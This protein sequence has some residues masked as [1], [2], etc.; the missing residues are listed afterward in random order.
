VDE[1][2]DWRPQRLPLLG[3]VRAGD[4]HEAIEQSGEWIDLPA[5]LRGE[6]QFALR[7]QGE[8]MYPTL[9][10]GDIVTIRLQPTAQPG[11]LAVAS[12]DDEVTLKRFERLEGLPTLVADNPA[13]KPVRCGPRARIVGIVTGS[14]RPPEVLHRRPP[15][16]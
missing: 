15:P 8:S 1:S 2:G 14:F 4:L 16:T 7:V 9:Q 10:E 11:Q 6:A 5:F 3:T 13:W 12:V